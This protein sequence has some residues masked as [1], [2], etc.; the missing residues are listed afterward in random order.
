MNYFE[1]TLLISPDNTKN[2]LIDISKTFE[3]LVV[4]QDGSIISKEDWGLR[5][6]AYKIK[7]LKKAF[8]FFYQIN[9]EGQKIQALKKNISKNEKIIRYLIIKVNVH[10]KLP[11]KMYTGDE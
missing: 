2:N 3:K 10:D 9:L 5:N 4:D 1:V 7:S 6:L 11:T 8:Y